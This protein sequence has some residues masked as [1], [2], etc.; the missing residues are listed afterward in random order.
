MMSSNANTAGEL[1]INCFGFSSVK[2]KMADLNR[3]HMYQTTL[4]DSI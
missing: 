1:R 3:T 2:K 4:N